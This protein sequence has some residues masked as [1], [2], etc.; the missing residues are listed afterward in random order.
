MKNSLF[1][2][3]YK[4]KGINTFYKFE[5]IGNELL[6]NNSSDI[7]SFSLLESNISSIKLTFQLALVP[8]LRFKIRRLEAKKDGMVLEI[9]IRFSNVLI[10]IYFLQMLISLACFVLAFLYLDNGL[11]KILLMILSPSIYL[12]AVANFYFLKSRLLKKLIAI[13]FIEVLQ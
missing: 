6:K 4:F 2:P 13:S 3:F 9:D 12:F 7:F 11:L 10:S 1:W 8:I 5:E